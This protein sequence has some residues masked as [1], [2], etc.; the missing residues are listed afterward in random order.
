MWGFK[1]LVR[2]HTIYRNIREALFCGYNLVQMGDYTIRL[3]SP[4]KSI[5]DLLY[6]NK[7]ETINEFEGLRIN[8]Q[9]AVDLVNIPRLKNYLKLFQSRIMEKRV[10]KFIDYINAGT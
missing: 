6:L 3:A 9:V 5:L 4:E 10:N 2:D 8:H 7:L 1:D